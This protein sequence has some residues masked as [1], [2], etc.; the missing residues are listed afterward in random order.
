VTVFATVSEMLP[1]QIS[2]NVSE[3]FSF[4]KRTV[5]EKGVGLQVEEIVTKLLSL[6]NQLSTV[7]TIANYIEL[8]KEEAV[9]S[10]EL[11]FL[12]LPEEIPVNVKEFL[13]KANILSN[14]I[15]NLT[16]LD[17]DFAQ[18]QISITPSQKLKNTLKVEIAKCII[19]LG[20]HYPNKK[21]FIKKYFDHTKNP[22]K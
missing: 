22:P 7:D 1:P 14:F 9:K 13:I 16:D 8:T 15:D 5:L 3:N 20:S 6:H 18:G 4:L 2:E 17:S 10:A 21:R 19:F 11:A 12:F